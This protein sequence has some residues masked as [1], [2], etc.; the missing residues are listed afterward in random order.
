MM[1]GDSN[2]STW[3]QFGKLTVAAGE[4]AS[5]PYIKGVAACIATILEI[6]ELAGKNN[7]D[8]QDLVESIRTTIRI[9]R[10]TVE[11]HGDTSATVFHDICV[12]LQKYLE[13]LI[14]ELNAIQHKSK[15]KQQVNN[16]KVDYL[17][18]A[19]TDTR[20][21]MSKMQDVLSTTITQAQSHIT[22]TVKSQA[23]D[24][25]GKIC[26]LSNSQREL[27]AQI[28][29]KLQNP[30][31]YYKGQV[32]ELFPG[33]IYLERPVSPSRHESSLRYQDMYG[34]VKCSNKAK[35]ICVYQHSSDN[36]EAMLKWFNMIVDAYIPLKHPNI[37]QVFGVCRSPSLPAI[38]FHGEDAGTFVFG[39]V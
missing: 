8:L 13:S 25:Q 34:T 28:C 21:A 39:L 4:M 30:K 2:I 14:A 3:I 26:S 19:T 16:I 29:E 22:S 1:P 12:D 17:I 31:G 10:E 27:A 35:I 9:I 6:I 7:E 23:H 11:V 24:V 32:R 15:Y 20:L 38:V 33:D 36:E 37:Q 18:L 5:F